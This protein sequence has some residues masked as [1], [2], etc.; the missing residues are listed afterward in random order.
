MGFMKTVETVLWARFSGAIV[1]STSVIP[2]LNC[3]CAV[4]GKSWLS[5]ISDTEQ[6]DFCPFCNMKQINYLTSR[7][8]ANQ[9]LT[10]SLIA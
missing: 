6:E 3:F 10:R 5:W 8:P 2:P 7:S 9:W 4:F 1:A